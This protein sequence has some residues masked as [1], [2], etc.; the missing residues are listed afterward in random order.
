M[1]NRNFRVGNIVSDGVVSP[2]QV[3]GIGEFLHG[4]YI[5]KEHGNGLVCIPF[6]QAVGIPLTEELILKCGFKK[7]RIKTAINGFYIIY[8]KKENFVVYLLSDFFEIELITKRGEQFN[9][10]KTFKKELHVLQNLH[11]FLTNTE[12]ILKP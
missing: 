9:L 7:V 10:F 3:T 6:E 1:E 5:Q 11:Y 2:F 4:K 8:Y 12:L